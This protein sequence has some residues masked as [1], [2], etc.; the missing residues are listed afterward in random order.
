MVLAP[1]FALV[2]LGIKVHSPGPALYGSPWWGRLGMAMWVW[3]FRTIV[4]G[5]DGVRDSEPGLPQACRP[6]IKIVNDPRAT[7]V[8]RFL[9]RW[10]MDELPQLANESDGFEA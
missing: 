4:D 9:G 1:L 10:C 6:S 8:G 7:P 3:N 5:C 2:T